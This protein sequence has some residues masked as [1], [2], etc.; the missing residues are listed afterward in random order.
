MRRLTALGI[1]TPSR[2][3]QRVVMV[4]RMLLPELPLDAVIPMVLQALWIYL[5]D[6]LVDGSISTSVLE[7]H[8]HSW[9]AQRTPDKTRLEPGHRL[10]RLLQDELTAWAPEYRYEQWWGAVR[11]F[12][13]AQ[14]I[15]RCTLAPSYLDYLATRTV[16]QGI[17][18]TVTLA[19]LVAGY[20]DELQTRRAGTLLWWAGCYIGLVNDLSSY[21]R[22]VREGTARTANARGVLAAIRATSGV[23]IDERLSATLVHRDMETSW[24]QL[25]RTLGP[26]S[27]WTPIDWMIAR[28][29]QLLHSGYAQ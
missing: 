7:E 17:P 14:L 11:Q 1:V 24:E 10:L 3:L 12:L 28:L 15:Q 2:H 25:N 5:T 4:T 29:A 19:A 16:A 23:P 6:A 21:E 18:L 8:L 20:A 27:T 13:D 26:Q 22:E 9:Q